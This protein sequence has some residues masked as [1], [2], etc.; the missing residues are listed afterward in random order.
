MVLTQNLVTRLFLGTHLRQWLH[1]QMLVLATGLVARS[2]LGTRRWRGCTLR[3]WY[4]PS[5]WLHAYLLVLAVML[6]ARGEHGTRQHVGCTPVL[7]YAL[8]SWLHAI[9]MVLARSMVTRS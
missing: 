1:A 5:P 2:A 9:L 7:W 6:V 4:S 8:L 3:F